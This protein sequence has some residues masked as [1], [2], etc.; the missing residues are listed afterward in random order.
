MVVE[1]LNSCKSIFANSA[2]WNRLFM[3]ALCYFFTSLF[4]C[5]LLLHLEDAC[6]WSQL[7]IFAVDYTCHHSN[8]KSCLL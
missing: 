5:F 7:F 2:K 4:S 6:C 8:A 1:V 3:S